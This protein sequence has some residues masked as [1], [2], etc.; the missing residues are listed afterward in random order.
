MFLGQKV[1][2]M[3]DIIL[4]YSDYSKDYRQLIIEQPEDNLDTL[5]I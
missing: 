1:V 4:G 3:L 2:A 5:Y